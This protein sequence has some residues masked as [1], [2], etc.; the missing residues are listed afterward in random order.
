MQAYID[1][2]DKEQTVQGIL[3]TF[4]VLV[5]A[6]I[7][8]KVLLGGDSAYLQKLQTVA[9]PF[10]VGTIIAFSAAALFFYTERSALLELH[11]Y[12]ALAIAR[13]VEGSAIRNDSWTLR[14]S[15]LYGDSYE[16][17]NPYQCAL[18]SLYAA[19]AEAIL[20]ILAAGF[21]KLPPWWTWASWAL[22]FALLTFAAI[23]VRAVWQERLEKDKSQ[24]PQTAR[25]KRRLRQLPLRASTKTSDPKA[26]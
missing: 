13:E 17:W 22:S 15:L 23:V 25:V 16:L 21:E 3:S 24:A 20:G 11:G 10:V 18:G 5:N 7:L 19:G 9:F 26:D 8:S 6:A 2:L 14:E 12:I 4:C 1:H